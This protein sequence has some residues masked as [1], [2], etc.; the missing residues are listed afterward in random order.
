M[1][2]FSHHIH[3]G[4]IIKAIDMKNTEEY[5]LF[6]IRYRLFF[7]IFLQPYYMHTACL[8]KA[9][10][11]VNV[12]ILCLSEYNC[13]MFSADLFSVELAQLLIF[14]NWLVIQKSS[15]IVGESVFT[16]CKWLPMQWAVF[17]LWQ[18]DGEWREWETKDRVSP[19][20]DSRRLQC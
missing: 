18:P 4:E 9:S 15:Q 14:T 7:Q 6:H 1:A 2:L 13:C 8:L 5:C 3:L 11:G 16:L 17:A 20:P 10:N 12:L 19:V